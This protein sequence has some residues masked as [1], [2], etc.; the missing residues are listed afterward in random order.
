MK[1]CWLARLAATVS[2]ATS[3]VGSLPSIAGSG[4]VDLTRWST[5]DIATVADD[6]LGKLVKKGHR[7]FT[8]TANEIGPT[9]PDPARR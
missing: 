9:M 8:D 5:P 6:S 1:R 7:L 4:D 3:V 2:V